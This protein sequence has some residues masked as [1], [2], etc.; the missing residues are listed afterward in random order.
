MSEED[1]NAN[2]PAWQAPPLTVTASSSPTDHR[3]NNVR[4]TELDGSEKEGDSSRGMVS[5]YIQST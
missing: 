4:R 2:A 1:A 3:R 5:S